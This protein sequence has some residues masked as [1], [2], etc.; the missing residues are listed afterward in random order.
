MRLYTPIVDEVDSIV[1]ADANRLY[2]PCS[3]V[4]QV[5]DPVRVAPTESPLDV[6]VVTCMDPDKGA[7]ES[8]EPS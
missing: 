6:D 2:E 3:E 5:V 1:P 4:V 7:A 8:D